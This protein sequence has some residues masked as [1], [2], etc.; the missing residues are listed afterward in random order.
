MLDKSISEKRLVKRLTDYWSRIKGDAHLPLIMKFNHHALEDVWPFCFQ[1]SVQADDTHQTAT[2][3][4]DY[5]GEEIVNAYG[6]DMTGE[7]VNSSIHGIPGGSIINKIDEM[8]TLRDVIIE[9]G[10]FINDK[11]K[12]VKY[13]TCLLPFSSG[14]DEVTHVIAGLSWRAF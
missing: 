6:R 13:R 1:L 10:K 11:D 9:Q 8:V 14:H 7:R 2:Y 5:V 3:K 4:Y 12:V